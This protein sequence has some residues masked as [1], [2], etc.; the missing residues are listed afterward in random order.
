MISESILLVI[1]VTLLIINFLSFIVPFTMV[2]HL[3]QKRSID[4]NPF[5]TAEII[6]SPIRLDS[7]FLSLQLDLLE[8][9]NA[10]RIMRYQSMWMLLSLVAVFG[11]TS[12]TFGNEVPVW[13]YILLGTSIS[14]ML[15]FFC[16]FIN[17]FIVFFTIVKSSQK[18]GVMTPVK[19]ILENR[20]FCDSIKL[21]EMDILCITANSGE[22]AVREA[23]EILP[24]VDKQYRYRILQSLLF[25]ENLKVSD[26]LSH[27][28]M[29]KHQHEVVQLYPMTHNLELEY[30][31]LML[32]GPKICFQRKHL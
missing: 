17:I 29:R 22:N 19:A 27:E 12:L 28:D 2:H 6:Y 11:F 21:K 5:G 1:L 4:F 13:I 18:G 14:L 31:T 23:S 30:M 25:S 15:Y 20:K 32:T 10:T 8:H 7:A 9:T 26:L 24:H 3:I 16:Q